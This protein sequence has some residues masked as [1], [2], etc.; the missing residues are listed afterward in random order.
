MWT[1]PAELLEKLLTFGL[2]PTPATPPRLVRDAL[3][4]LYRYEIRRLRQRLLDKQVARADY[5]G[6][7]VQLRKKYWPLSLTPD[8]WERLTRSAQAP[9]AA[10]PEGSAGS[11]TDS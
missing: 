2:A 3:N 1:Y 7:V 9:S 8:G 6:L 5:A 11:A 10:P 4:D